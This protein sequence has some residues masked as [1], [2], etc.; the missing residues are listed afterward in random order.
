MTATE[1]QRT[2]TFQ[3]AAQDAHQTTETV[4]SVGFGPFR[5]SIDRQ[6]LRDGSREVRLGSRAMAILIALVERAGELVTREELVRIVWPQT[7]VEDVNLRVHISAL[8]RELRDDRHDPK[9]IANVAGRGYRFVAKTSRG[10]TG[11]PRIPANPERPIEQY[12]ASRARPS[13]IGAETAV[14]HILELLDQNRL[15]T[16]VGPPGSGKTTLA[17][18]SAMRVRD[19]FAA[20]VHLVNISSATTDAQGSADPA[21][22]ILSWAGKTGM[23]GGCLIIVD[24]CDQFVLSVARSVEVALRRYPDLRILATGPELLRAEGESAHH[25]RGLDLPDL[26]ADIVTIR[27]APAVALF[28]DRAIAAGWAHEP[29]TAELLEIALL[30]KRLDG[31]PRALEMAGLAAAQM[32]LAVLLARI[33]KPPSTLSDSSTETDPFSMMRSLLNWSIAALPPQDQR[34]LRCLSV[35]AGSFTVEQASFVVSDA[36]LTQAG[37]TESIHRLMGMSLLASSFP[38]APGR[39][40]IPNVIKVICHQEIVRNPDEI[41]VVRGRHALYVRL[42]LLDISHDVSAATIRQG[43]T[44]WNALFAEVQV[45]L[46][47]AAALIDADLYADLATLALPLGVAVGL[48]DEIRD[49]AEA[50]LR[51]LA[52]NPMNEPTRQ[53]DLTLALALLDL[54]LAGVSELVLARLEQAAAMADPTSPAHGQALLGLATAALFSGDFAKAVA[55]AVHAGGSLARFEPDTRQHYEVGAIVAAADHGCGEHQAALQ[56]SLTMIR[57]GPAILRHKT[58]PHR[59]DLRIGTRIIAARSHWILGQADQARLAV[60]EALGYAADENALALCQTLGW[61]ACPVLI[62]CGDDAGAA[63]HVRQLRL[64]A[65]QAMIPYWQGWAT[66]FEYIIKSLAAREGRGNRVWAPL[67]GDPIQRQTIVTMTGEFC[68]G[69][70]SDIGEPQGWCAPE[71]IRLSGIS[72]AQTQP[73]Q[74]NPEIRQRFKQAYAAAERQ[75]ALGWQLRAA[76]SLVRFPEKGRSTEDMLLLKE[77]VGRFSEGHQTSDMI[78]ARSLLRDNIP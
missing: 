32:G 58:D 74:A 66:V 35:F 39:L 54:P 19:T 65:D 76:I 73:E 18:E 17:L 75:A 25:V 41:A 78:V 24:G 11:Q 1:A 77:L 42:A 22:K 49:H 37:L 34:V 26:A 48:V 57:T 52:Q 63:K 61:A 45:A 3:V 5:L 43:R 9:Y 6:V 7:F 64:E 20:G 68:A 23:A 60:S 72:L 30:T 33:G 59:R 29:T 10:T 47:T 55:T 44:S 56:S 21:A 71:L 27:H 51:W 28:L 46:V 36:N 40:Y 4:E 69:S 15:V 38:D 8:R 70:A 16:V 50:A 67:T 12:I 13:L 14:Q 2:S 53:V 31:N 62:L